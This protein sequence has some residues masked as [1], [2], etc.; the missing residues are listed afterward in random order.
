[1]ARI[2]EATADLDRW[3]DIGHE[4]RAEA[5][6]AEH[7]LAERVRAAATAARISP[8]DYITAELGARP[9]DPAEAR[10][11]DRAVGGIEG[12]RTRN[13]VVDRDSA[14]G[15]K[16]KDHARQHDHREARERIELAQRQLRLQQ[17]QS[18]QRSAERVLE[19]GIGR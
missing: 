8:P 16:P 9:S 5:A 3:P 12:Y 4:I 14:L 11:W 19:R 17:A 7:V 10:Q 13:G 2:E 1:M 18:R 6:I 15:P